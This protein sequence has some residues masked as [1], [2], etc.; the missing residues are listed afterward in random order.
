MTKRKEYLLLTVILVF[1]V[2]T[3]FYNLGGPSLFN[4]ELA[5]VHFASAKNLS[6]MFDEYILKDV[7]PPGF[8]LMMYYVVRNLGDNEFW[9]R[10]PTAIAGIIAVLG[11]YLLGKYMFTYKEG[12]ISAA[13]T[14][15]FWAPLYYSQEARAYSFLFMFSIFSV[16]FWLKIIDA[17]RGHKR[18]KSF[19][20][21]NFIL[22]GI[23]SS[24]FQYL[25]LFFQILLGIAS[26]LI[27][28]KDRKSMVKMVLIFSVIALVFLP[29][30]PYALEQIG[31]GADWIKKPKL[32][33]FGYYLAFLFN[34]SPYILTIALILFVVVLFNS[35]KIKFSA[36]NYFINKDLFLALWLIVPFSIIFVKSLISKPVLTYYSLIISAPSAYLLFARGITLLKIKEN[37]K[38]IIA[39]ILFLITSWQLFIDMNYYSQPYK[40]HFII[41]G[42]RFNK[43]TKEMFREAA[44]YLK[45]NY[46]KYPNSVI[47]GYVWFPFYFDY[48]FEKINFAKKVEIHVLDSK[49]TVKFINNLLLNEK[50]YI[51]LI[52]GHKEI[53]TSYFDWMERKF[54]L[55]HHEAMVGADVWLYKI[56]E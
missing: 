36:D 23:L 35:I 32:L 1:A 22:I 8:Q 10:F 48:Y 15:V 27:F 18:I 38:G 13:M 49:D 54:K 31:V 34:L 43:R 44:I 53:D 4:D 9:L 11:M 56:D 26:I 24:Y 42:K 52:R 37:F 5:T 33:A 55:I 28:I 19:W 20:V 51:W 30:L 41:F 17:L 6:E 45:E 2:F 3:R 46:N 21:I 39:V 29:W 14:V 47:A 16:Y 50:E 7:H 25:G 12:L 40:D